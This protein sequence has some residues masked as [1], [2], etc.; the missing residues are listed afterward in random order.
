VKNKVETILS[1]SDKV[2]EEIIHKIDEPKIDSSNNVFNDLLSCVIEQ[3]IHYRSTKRVF[4]K[5]L[6]LSN[7]EQ[8]TPLNF[9]QFEEKALGTIKL[10]MR[11]NETILR[12]CE[13]WS[14]NNIEWHSLSSIKGI[15]KWTI[16]MIL[17]YTLNRPNVFPYDDFHLKQI[18]VS[19]YKLDSKVKLKSQMIRVSENWGEQK[20]LAVKYLL[21]WKHSVKGQL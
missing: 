10:S 4:Q 2:L 21:A 8:L 15:G 9:E 5:M 20:S 19:L 12:V 11:K 6:T 18:M 17:L 14:Q 16:D 1:S 7:L 3:Q 13:F